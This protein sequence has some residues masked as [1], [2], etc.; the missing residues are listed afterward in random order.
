M[1]INLSNHPFNGHDVQSNLAEERYGGF[2]NIPFPHVDP[3][4]DEAY[5]ERLA[6][7]LSDGL[8][9]GRVPASDVFHIMG[10][11]NLTFTLVKLLKSKGF[12]C[13]A[14]TTNRVVTEQDGVKKSVFTFKRFRSY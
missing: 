9:E 10:E 12:T 5:I 7:D 2:I 13:V 14:S 8:T 6:E 1:L 11:L 4:G 3:N